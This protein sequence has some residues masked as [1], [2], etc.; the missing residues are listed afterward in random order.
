MNESTDSP[1]PSLSH[2]PSHCLSDDRKD[3]FVR[4][5]DKLAHGSEDSPPMR[6]H[7]ILNLLV[8]LEDPLSDKAV[9]ILSVLHP[10][11]MGLLDLGPLTKESCRD[12]IL[13]ML[14]EHE[15]KLDELVASAL[16]ELLDD[17]LLELL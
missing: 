3:T 1:K 16:W 12:A 10:G 15:E 8:L 11:A 5:L 14:A 9:Q 2:I 6:W 4:L 13:R 7:K 17:E